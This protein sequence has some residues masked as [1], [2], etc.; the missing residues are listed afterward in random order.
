MLSGITIWHRTK[1]ANENK[2]NVAKLLV[3]TLLFCGFGGM[4][5]VA[6]DPALD[7]LVWAYPDHLAG[8]DEN[9]VTWTDGTVMPVGGSQKGR[10]FQEMLDAPSILEQFSIPYPLGMKLK[11]PSLNE[12]PG[13]FR[14]SAFFTKMYGDCRRGQVTKLLK[15]VAW[16]TRYGGG[17]LMATSVN[18]VAE[19]L[20]QVSRELEML[21]GNLMKYLVPSAGTY[22]CRQIAGTARM[23]VH[24]YG[25]AIDINDHYGDYWLWEKNKTGRFEWSNRIPP[26]IVDIFERHGFIW[27]GKWYHFDMMH[28]EY[29]PELI[30]LAKRGWPRGYQ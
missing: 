24:S 16:L 13:R 22:M 30:E 21:P 23:S 1:S 17:T 20:N 2:M 15:P 18:G 29:R 25:A 8:H 4:I 9:S 10:S 12:D 7:A 11:A 6:A 3:S 27:G 19:N 28:F 26:E 5:S 14:N